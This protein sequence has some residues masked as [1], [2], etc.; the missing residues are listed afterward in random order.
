VQT[1]LT[2]LMA[3]SLLGDAD[4]VA[5]LLDAGAMPDRQDELGTTALIASASKGHRAVVERLLQGG[6]SPNLA[7]KV[8]AVS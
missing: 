4:S 1:G 3:C 5:A 6:A 2:A 8:C 7:R